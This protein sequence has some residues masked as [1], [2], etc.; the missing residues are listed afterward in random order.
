[1][2][3]NSMK[4]PLIIGGMVIAVLIT[5][6]A[7][8]AF[9]D[10]QRPS[11]SIV[12]EKTVQH[13]PEAAVEDSRSASKPDNRSSSNLMAYNRAVQTFRETALSQKH[14]ADGNTYN[15]TPKS[16]YE[17]KKTSGRDS[18]GDEIAQDSVGIAS[19]GPSPIEETNEGNP[20]NSVVKDTWKDNARRISSGTGSSNDDSVQDYSL[21]SEEGDDESPVPDEDLPQDEDL[22]EE[23][24]PSNQSVVVSRE[25]ISVSM[26]EGVISV[27]LFVLADGDITSGF[28]IREF[29]PGGWEVVESLPGH[30]KFNN[31][32]GE[33]TWSFSGNNV[34][35][36]RITYTIQKNEY[37]NDRTSFNGYYRYD[38]INGNPVEM[39]IKG[40]NG[41]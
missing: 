35:S 20:D 32:T 11:T 17:R 14:E 16:T 8:I 6:A 28:I 39:R 25:F 18:E 9:M 15:A 1:M 7:V 30:N 29:I 2:N 33:M 36:R 34:M 22:P 10:Y 27:A 4:K 24:E 37:L 19:T 31:Q 21:P 40:V 23:T 41:V 12:Q 26:N 13:S 3:K 5:V 38:D